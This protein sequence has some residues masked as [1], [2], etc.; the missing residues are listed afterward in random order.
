M[1]EDKLAGYRGSLRKALESSG[2]E[3]GDILE[4]NV[5]NQQYRGSLMPRVETYD[6][7][8]IIIKMKSG[9]NVGL[10]FNKSMKIMK[11]GSSPKPEF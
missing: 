1:T 11:T 3:I 8:H 9:Y 10:E 4:V 5:N 7:H 2:V 6:E